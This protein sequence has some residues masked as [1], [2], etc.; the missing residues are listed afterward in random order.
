MYHCIRLSLLVCSAAFGLS[1]AL[2]R[3]MAAADDILI[4]DFEESDYGMWSVTGEAFG[5]APAR[6]T[7]PGQMQVG[8][9]NGA[10]LVN[11]FTG[12]DNSTGTLTSKE[13]RIERKFISFLIGGGKNEEQLALHL[14][15]DGKVV[16]SATGLNDQQG[17][18]EAL[19]PS[20]WDVTELAGKTAKLRIIDEA[21]GSWGHINVDQ[22]V[23]TDD[24][25]AGLL[26]NAQR[27]FHGINEVL[28]LTY[29]QRCSKTQSHAAHR[30]PTT[31]PK[32][33]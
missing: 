32:R 26:T 11:S 19:E 25:P 1:A 8:G 21:K 17:G 33:C 4:A 6:G 3:D 30:W 31:G 2:N 10:G 20:S 24:R 18:S 5:T 7:L 15:I 29:S 14:L 16:R 9:F 23:L 12:G 13:F 22:I 28:A 27:T